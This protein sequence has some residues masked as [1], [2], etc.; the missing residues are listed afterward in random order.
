[1]ELNDMNKEQLKEELMRRG[2]SSTGRKADLLIR[3]REAMVHD[4]EDL[5]IDEF[6]TKDQT[7]VAVECTTGSDTPTDEFDTK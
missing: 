4:G 3:L 2:F 7:I 1:M 6:D 5:D